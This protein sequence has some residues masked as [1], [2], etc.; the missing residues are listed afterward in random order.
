MTL[1]GDF[2]EKF[3]AVE[4][5]AERRT[6]GARL[7]VVVGGSL[8]EGLIVRADEPLLVQHLAEG[9]PV[10]A[11]VAVEGNT[12]RTFFGMITD[13]E[14][15]YVN[16]Q[17]RSLNV[18]SE[19][20]RA[21]YLGTAFHCLFHVKLMLVLEGGVP[22][23]VRSLPLHHAIVRRATP[24]EVRAL[25]STSPGEGYYIGTA[26]DDEQIEIWIDLE[27]LIERS[28]GIFG[29]SGTGK[30]FLTLPLLAS[31][32]KKNLASVLVF[33][34]HNDY[35][36]TLK[37]DRNMRFKGLKQLNAITSRV[38]VVAL[39]EESSKQR[40]AP[41]EFALRIGYNQIE[42][43]DIEI[44]RAELSLS[45]VQVNALYALQ[46]YARN[47]WFAELL[48]DEPSEAVGWLLESGKLN[49]GTFAA[50][51]RKLS[52]LARFPF[53]E[54]LVDEDYAERILAH[55][56]RG[57]SVVIEFG[58]YGNDL[59]A[60]LLVANFLTRRIHQ[61]YVDMKERAEGGGP[62]P[63]HLVIAIEEAHKFL[64]PEVARQT[65]FGTIARELR[66]YNVTLLIVDQRPSQIDTEVM[67][68]LG[69]R[70]TAALSDEKD[71]AAVLT[72]VSGAAELR[73][74]LASLESKQQVLILGHAVNMPVVVRTRE[75]GEAMYREFADPLS[76]LPPEKQAEERRKLLG[77][78]SYNDS[79]L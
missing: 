14:L 70:I 75:Y 68:Q 19:F 29:R 79:V 45:D 69:T 9:V 63:R 30:T 55:L 46:R 32:I 18:T 60:Y 23:P 3:F 67:S 10:G 27:R 26:V 15:D 17:A 47:R 58:R 41:Y 40:D 39:D 33:D 20:Q 7:G 42:P 25:L 24:E 54:P 34:M 64:D 5:V 48:S 44:L 66:K 72:G 62:E 6:L 36:Y 74:V 28:T 65:I 11:Y 38:V 76:E 35:G 56:A 37:G 50:M 61:R 57:E 78:R 51:Q 12:D 59:L 73:Q 53:L 13:V 52:R 16:P 21:V 71:I 1:D 4:S 49:E 43:Q 22:K 8:S 77:R 2:P 31:V